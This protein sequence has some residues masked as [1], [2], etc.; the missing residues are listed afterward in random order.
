[1]LHFLTKAVGFRPHFSCWGVIQLE[2]SGPFDGTT[3]METFMQ[4]LTYLINLK[5]GRISTFAKLASPIGG[6]SIRKPFVLIAF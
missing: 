6:E 4:R 1:M 3:D 2:F 5:R